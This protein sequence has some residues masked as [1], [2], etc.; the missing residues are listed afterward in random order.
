MADEYI[1]RIHH[2]GSLEFYLGCYCYLFSNHH[3][4][5]MD[6]HHCASRRPLTDL[7]WVVSLVGQLMV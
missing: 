7:L 3:S 4:S 5:T 1:D 2:I 6:N